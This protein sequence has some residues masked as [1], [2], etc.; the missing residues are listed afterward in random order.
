M[1]IPNSQH[2]QLALLAALLAFDPNGVC[3]LEEHR[4]IGALGHG[5]EHEGHFRAVAGAEISGKGGLEGESEAVREEGGRDVVQRSDEAGERGEELVAEV[6]VDVGLEQPVGIADLRDG[7]G[8]RSQRSRRRRRRGRR[9]RRG[10][11]RVADDVANEVAGVGE[12][13][14]R[15]RKKGGKDMLTAWC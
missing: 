15:D 11:G 6:P 8:L 3:A 7:E 5:S 12:G 10:I 2:V 13:H 9:G 14:W 1:F 4:E